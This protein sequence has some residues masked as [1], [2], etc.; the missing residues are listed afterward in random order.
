MIFRVCALAPSPKRLSTN[1]EWCA[2]YWVKI[3]ADPVTLAAWKEKKKADNK[4]RW[5]SRSEE[6]R[7]DMKE[8]ARLRQ[9]KRKYGILKKISH[10]QYG[11]QTRDSGPS[12]LN[13]SSFAN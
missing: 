7:E 5:A 10:S 8:R 12:F 6:Q 11:C 13:S 2:Q 1:A 9:L 3:K 4:L